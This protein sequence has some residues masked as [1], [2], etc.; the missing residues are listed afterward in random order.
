MV[1]GSN[2]VGADADAAAVVVVVVEYGAIASFG[3]DILSSSVG[4]GVLYDE[5]HESRESK[6][7]EYAQEGVVGMGFDIVFWESCDFE[8]GAGDGAGGFGGIFV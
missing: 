6:R 8:W 4:I 2:G 3:C 5:V 1:D 7:G